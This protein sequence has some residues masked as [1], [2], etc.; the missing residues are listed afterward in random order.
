[1][2]AQINTRR[3]KMPTIGRGPMLRSELPV[4]TRYADLRWGERV[5][6]AALLAR[7]A[8]FSPARELQ[9]LRQ[10]AKFDD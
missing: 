7:R 10:W 1:M 8:L 9:V 5:K 4:P 6:L 3:I 2:T